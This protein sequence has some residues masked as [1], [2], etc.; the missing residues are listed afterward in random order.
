MK[1][2]SPPFQTPQEF[3]DFASFWPFYL[4]QHSKLKTRW[5]HFIGTSFVFICLICSIAYSPWFLLGAPT[6]AYGLAWYSHFFIEGNKPATFGHPLWSLRADF[7]MYLY[8][9]LG[10]LN[11]EFDRLN[12][13][14]DDD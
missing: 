2:T 12:V 7:K 6:I 14:F 3:T 10:K 11:Q 1:Q 8:M 13:P 4:S 9:L 5:W